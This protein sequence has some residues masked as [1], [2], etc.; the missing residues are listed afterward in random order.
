MSKKLKTSIRAK[1]N[2]LCRRIVN[3]IGEF[4]GAMGLLFSIALLCLMFIYGY[5]YLLST[6]YFEVKETSVRGL[7]ELTEKDI[8]VLAE[9]PT[10]QN[11]LSVN[12]DLLVKR[13]SANLWVKN[14]YVGR[15]LPNRLVLEVRE[16][17]PLAM[18]RQSGNFYLMDG[19]GFVFKKL[20]KSDE[21]D[22]PI[23]TGINCTEKGKSKLLLSA[24][25]LLKTV[26][27]S[28][29]Y[30]YLGAISEVNVDDVFGLSL[31]TDAGLY[32]KMGT[33]DYE[34]KLNQ[35]SVVM[36][37]LEKRGLKKGYI[38][39]DLCDVTKITIQRKNALGRTEPGKKSK[40][41]RT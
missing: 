37:D 31:L 32:L 6:P 38:C 25:S 34:N 30:N 41:Y 3:G 19:E 4:I 40:Q 8:L 33:D 29:R 35:L 17:I 16:R 39:A 26:A 15:E 13:I 5:S 21:V 36:D 11:L 24:L 1:K 7:K 22:L 12:T 20:G 9:I 18:V 23:L 10:R 2:R 14:V 28:D 27:A